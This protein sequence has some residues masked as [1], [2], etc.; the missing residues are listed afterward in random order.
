MFDRKVIL[1]NLML[2]NMQKCMLATLL[3]F[4]TSMA[5]MMAAST[6]ACGT[7]LIVSLVLRQQAHGE[8]PDDRDE[9]ELLR[10]RCRQETSRQSAPRRS[11]TTCSSLRH[12]NPPKPS[13]LKRHNARPFWQFKS[14]VA[15]HS[16]RS[17]AA[18][19]RSNQF[20]I[21]SS[22][23]ESTY[24]ADSIIIYTQMVSPR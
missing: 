11:H 6:P 13:S 12:P 8:D 4:A 22:V 24:Y 21:G 18:A 7:F 10:R 2:A 20:R 3:C 9:E 14:P 15:T 23:P 1:L 16:A 17:G 5:G 19:T